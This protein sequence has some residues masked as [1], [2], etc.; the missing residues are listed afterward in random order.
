MRSGRENPADAL[1][2]LADDVRELDADRGSSSAVV[3]R[4]A[5]VRCA[6]A[7]NRGDYA[8]VVSKLPPGG[9][10]FAP[11]VRFNADDGREFAD[12]GWE[13][14]PD[15]GELAPDGWELAPDGWELADDGWEL[16]DDVTELPP[17]VKFLAD[18]GG[19]CLPRR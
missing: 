6:R 12:N 7:D 10:D 11:V 9:C 4:F 15:R 14:A 16:A 3:E 2:V 18:D 8:G 1:V 13:L 5:A 17:D 19:R